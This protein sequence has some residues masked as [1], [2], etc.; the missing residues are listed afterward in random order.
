MRKINNIHDSVIYG[1]CLPK[2]AVFMI[3]VITWSNVHIS[4]GTTSVSIVFR[5]PTDSGVRGSREKASF[6]SQPNSNLGS[7]VGT[8]IA[9][10]IGLQLPR[11]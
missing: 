9:I 4:P 3:H 1:P 10:Y 5:L 11:T 2:R 8:V 7:L 6:P